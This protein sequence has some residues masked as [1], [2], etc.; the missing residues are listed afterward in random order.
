MK[1]VNA[2]VERQPKRVASLQ[3]PLRNFAR[4]PT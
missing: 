3:Q 1:R 2:F 4:R